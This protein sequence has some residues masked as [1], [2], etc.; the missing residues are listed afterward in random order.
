MDPQ[1][2]QELNNLKVKLE[3]VKNQ[4]VSKEEAHD[5]LVEVV[6]K[7]ETLLAMFSAPEGA[8]KPGMF[9]RILKP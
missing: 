6:A 5:L 1:V 9:D 7:L 2:F 8:G 3:A 4:T